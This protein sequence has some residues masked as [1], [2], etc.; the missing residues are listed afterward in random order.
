MLLTRDQRPTEGVRVTFSLRNLLCATTLLA[1]LAAC[2]LSASAKTVTLQKMVRVSLETDA[3][4]SELVVSFYMQGSILGFIVFEIGGDEVDAVRDGD[5]L[6]FSAPASLIGGIASA[7]L[8]ALEWSCRVDAENAS[9]P[10]YVRSFAAVASKPTTA[11]ILPQ[12]DI[13]GDTSW[14]VLP[15]SLVA[16][17][18]GGL[19]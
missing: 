10:V 19:L 16:S 2:P 5:R 13:S 1:L 18:V 8:P 15:Q 11:Q 17:V 4:P 14:I 3:D 6:N 9:A 12:G 7:L